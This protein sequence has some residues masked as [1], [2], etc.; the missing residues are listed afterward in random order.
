MQFSIVA[1]HSSNSILRIFES[2]NHYLREKKTPTTWAQHD[3]TLQKLSHLLTKENRFY[4]S[5]PRGTLENKL[6]D[7]I[8]LFSRKKGFAF[9]RRR[10]NLADQTKQQSQRACHVPQMTSQYDTNL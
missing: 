4:Y 7:L 3:K 8:P 5:D 9:K 6:N 10:V 2:V 1:I